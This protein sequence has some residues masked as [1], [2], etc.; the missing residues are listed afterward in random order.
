LSTFGGDLD[1][2]VTSARSD[3]RSLEAQSYDTED[4]WGV[5]TGFLESDV[6]NTGAAGDDGGDWDLE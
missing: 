6:P 4:T 3:L 2:L 5:G 1:S